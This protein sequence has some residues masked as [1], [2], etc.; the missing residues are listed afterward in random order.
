MTT[1]AGANTVSN[2]NI[3]LMWEMKRLRTG[4][5]V[6]SGRRSQTNTHN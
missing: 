2:K 5:C 4:R 6:S 3:E 1:E